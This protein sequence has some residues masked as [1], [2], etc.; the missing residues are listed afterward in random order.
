MIDHVFESAVAPHGK[1]FISRGKRFFFKAVR[2]EISDQPLDFSGKLGL[3]TRLGELKAGH[4]TAVLT[5]GS[6][7]EVVLDI[8]GQLGLAAIVELPLNGEGLLKRSGLRETYARLTRTVRIFRDH[9]ALAGYLL[10]IGVDMQWLKHQGVER[11]Q[12]R[13]RKVIDK[14]KQIDSN[15]MVALN[16]RPETRGLALLEEDLIYSSVPPLTPF[17]LKN[18]IVGLH[19]IAESR[20]V[21]IEFETPTPEQDERVASAF[22]S[23]VA[24][25]VANPIT[26]QVAPDLLHIR[27]L[28]SGELLPFATLNGTCPPVPRHTP[29]VSVVVCA[30]NAE[31]TM[32]RCLESLRTLD[33]A[34]HEVII[35]DDGS[36]D[37][38]AE[39]A[40]DFPEFRLIR[41]SNKGLSVARNVGLHAA[42]GEIIAYTDSDCVVDPHWLTLMVGAMVENKFDACGGPNYAPH[43]ESRTEACVA[44][45]P[46]AP[47]H[48][49]IDEDRAEHLAGCNMVFRKS[50]LTTIGGFDPQFTAAGDDVD[51]CWRAIDAGF[52]LGFCPAAFVWHFRRNTVKAYYGQ[53]RGYGKAEAMLYFKYPERFNSLG[54]I[55][56]RGRIPGLARMLPGGARKKILWA[57][58]SRAFFQTIYEREQG[59]I[60]FLP[61]TLEWQLFWSLVAIATLAAGWNI[62]PALAM[63]TLGPIWSLCYAWRAPIEKSHD[64]FTSR[65]IVAMLTYTGPLAR[66]LTRYRLRLKGAWSAIKGVE[67]SPRQRPTIKWSQ[68][69]VHL[70]YWNEKWTPRETLLDRMMRLFSR[71]GHP[72]IVDRGWNDFDFEVR[73]DAWT[74]VEIKTADE[75]HESGKLK[76]HVLARVRLSWLTRTPLIAGIACAAGCAAFGLG[77][78]ALIIGEITTVAAAFALSEAAES[79]RL[80][81]R[82]IEQ[83]AAELDLIPLGKPTAAA[84]RAAASSQPVI[85]DARE[86]APATSLIAENRPTD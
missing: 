4:T 17:E 47:C 29:M 39:I 12:K 27:Q 18:Y 48:V 55:M 28:T 54:Q 68:R 49:L 78:F 6:N 9:Q 79:G 60:K 61:Q 7:A 58:G 40:T 34:N 51:I 70:A 67:P 83:C 41:Q 46:G 24:G 56:W 37:S 53:Q 38:T 35:V 81:Y 13:L 25:V 33:Y 73:P 23:G 62:V 57:T 64:S 26:N 30:Y 8:A 43:E 22:A 65:L 21:V 44:V 42:R 85:D 16:H 14:I 66:A 80:A 2:L 82:T 59:L 86:I 84:R 71:A 15:A 74:R 3:R 1:F 72:L 31:R 75:E 45:S 10:D 76:N 50:M 36:R 11:V 32:R 20:P 69:A 19:N 52:T 77:A 63:L 5:R